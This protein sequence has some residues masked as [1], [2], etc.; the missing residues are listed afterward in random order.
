MTADAAS[1]EIEGGTKLILIVLL[2]C[3][4]LA[5]VPWAVFSALSFMG[6]DA[7]FSWMV[8]VVMA[9][10]WIY[11]VLVLVCSIVAFSLNG[12]GRSSAAVWTMLVP[13]I[14]PGGWFLVLLDVGPR[15]AKYF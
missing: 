10:V 4:L 13:V 5:L 14:G 2:V 3:E 8:V 11:P 15:L 7:G 6:F 9:P 1:A 12:K